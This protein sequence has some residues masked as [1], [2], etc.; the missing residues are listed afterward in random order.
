[1]SIEEVAAL[2]TESN[3][4]LHIQERLA[5]F[6]NLISQG[7]K[8]KTPQEVCKFEWEKEKKQPREYTK[9]RVEKNIKQ[10]EKWL[11]TR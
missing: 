2:L 8:I 1:M 7:A 11:K 10:A 9:E 6:F 4:Q 3:K 5:C